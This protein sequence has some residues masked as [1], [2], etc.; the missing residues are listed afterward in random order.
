MPDIE[1]LRRFSLVAA[2]A[3]IFYS[4]AGIS[5]EPGAKASVLGIPFII[6]NPDLLLVGF[7]LASTYGLVRF[8]YYAIML[9][10]SPHRNRKD[11]LHKL[12][13]KDGYGN[14]NGSVFFGPSEYSTTPMVHE[15]SEVEDE[16]KSVVGA[17]SKIGR[18]R[19]F[20]EIK[21]HQGCDD[22][23]ELYCVFYAEIK[24]PLAC[25]MAA[26][27]QDIDY[28]APIWANLIAL[29]MVVLTWT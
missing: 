20:G 8:Y 9:N 22:D 7:L 3:L 14:Y 13:A 24:I 4:A 12:H 18:S 17:F 21:S 28:T 27:A 1:K 11:L 23:G 6:K 29:T 19:V 2:L 16:L 26:I 15:H 25:R 5:L 10:D